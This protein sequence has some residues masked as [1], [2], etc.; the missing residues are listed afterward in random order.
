MAKARRGARSKRLADRVQK[1]VDGGANSAEGIH[2]KVANLPLDL[3]E[4]VDLFEDAVKDVRKIQDRSIGA[5][6]GLVR[7]INHEVIRAAKEVLGGA[8]AAHKARPRKKAAKAR[9]ARETTA[10]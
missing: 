9:P 4:Q 5:V 2:K 8:P 10:A 1:A 3:L 7:G 6:Y